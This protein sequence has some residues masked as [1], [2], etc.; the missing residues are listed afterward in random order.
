MKLY[1]QLAVLF[2]FTVALSL[3]FPQSARAVDSIGSA[4]SATMACPF[5][6]VPHGKCYKVTISGCAGG[7]FIAQAKLNTS[8]AGTPVGTVILTIGGGGNFWYDNAAT[9]KIPGNCNGNCGEQT[10]LDLNAA[11]Y[12]TI[13]T[14]FSDPSSSASEFAGWLTG[15]TT[16]AIGPRELACRYA[17]MINWAWTTLLQS[18]QTHPVCATGNSAGS[19]ALA[20]AL[21]QYQLGSGS[22]QGPVLRLA[23]LTSGPP[24]S[25]L[26]H[27][28][29]SKS[30]APV[31]T[32]SCPVN[33]SI[34][35]SLGLTDAANFV[36]P[37]YDGDDD[38]VGSTCTPDS[39]DPCAYTLK[40]NLTAPAVLLHDSILSDIDPP[41][42]NFSTTVRV[43]FGAAD[44]SAS[45]ALGQ[46]WLNEI[47]STKSQ[48]C[49][50]FAQHSLPGYTDGEQQ[51]V[52]DIKALCK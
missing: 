25:R 37:A 5:A 43:L 44:G 1:P 4:T 19:A 7:T 47:T 3:M 26:D 23:E 40:N 31:D 48:A 17:T 18:D 24:F 6:G 12:T 32:V 9:F 42:V 36:D 45:V 35:E 41:L 34:N 13:Q 8:T 29:L 51:I 10:V 16:S 20:Y 14:N 52:A 30:K 33:A 38:C 28:C 2:L 11:A 39:S 15:S 22:G 49:V 46:E 21:A 50:P 27:A